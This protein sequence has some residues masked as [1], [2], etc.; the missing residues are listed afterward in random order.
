[1]L[2]ARTIIEV[3]KSDIAA[4]AYRD[5]VVIGSATWR[6]KRALAGDDDIWRLELE[7]DERPV[8]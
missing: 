7:T 5:T 6:V 1:M 8:I 2:V 3:Q 4:W